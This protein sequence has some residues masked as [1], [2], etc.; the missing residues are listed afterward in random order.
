LI[1]ADQVH[2]RMDERKRVWQSQQHK[3]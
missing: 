2:A 3:A 1:D